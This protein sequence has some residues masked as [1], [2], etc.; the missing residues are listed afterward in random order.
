MCDRGFFSNASSTTDGMATGERRCQ[1]CSG[2]HVTP[3]SNSTSCDVTCEDGTEAGTGGIDCIVSKVCPKGMYG[4]RTGSSA[5]GNYSGCTACPAGTFLSVPGARSKDDC[6]PCSP[7]QYSSTSGAKIS[8]QCVDCERGKF[9]DKRGANTSSA[10]ISCRELGASYQDELGQASCKPDLCE[11]GKYAKPTTN[12]AVLTDPRIRTPC[13]DC[14]K[15]R[16]SLVRGLTGES[17]CTP[18]SAGFYATE[19]GATSVNSCQSCSIGRFGNASGASEASKCY[20]CKLGIEY[21]DQPGQAACK[22]AACP[23]GQYGSATSA[24]IKPP[25]SKCPK[26]RYSVAAGLVSEDECGPCPLGTYGVVEGAVSR[27]KGCRDCSANNTYGIREGQASRDT[28]CDDCQIGTYQDEAGKASCKPTS[29]P[30]GKAGIKPPN[31]TDCSTGRYSQAMGLTQCRDCPAGYVTREQGMA[32]CT[33]C[34]SYQTT[35][36]EG[37]SDCMCE[38]Q[39]YRVNF[40]CSPCPEAI[41][42][43]RIGSGLQ[44]ITLKRGMWRAG[45]DDNTFVKC[46]VNKTCIGG[47]DTAK[48]CLEGHHGP[49]CAICDKSYSR[50]TNSVPCSKCPENMTPSVFAALGAGIGMVAFLAICLFFNRRTPNGVLRPLINAAQ[51]M[52]VVFMFPVDWPDSIKGLKKA[53][54]GINLDFVEIASPACLGMP[55]SYY[56]RLASMIVVTGLVIG[57]PWLASRLRYWH[58]AAKWRSTVQGHLRDTFLL[59]VLLHPTLSGQAFA[60]FRCRTV[61]YVDQSAAAGSAYESKQYLMADYSLECYDSA[62][63]GIAALVLVVILGFSLG[64]PILFAR[65]LWVRRAELQ[66]PETK[67]LLG[68]LYMSYK[69]DLYWFESV[70]M[71]FKLALWATLVFFEHG[72]QFQLA[73][74]A[75]ICFVQLGVHARYEPYET[76]FKNLMQY[77]SYTLVAFTAF[78]GLL[79]NFIT[80]SAKLAL[81]TLQQDEYKRLRAQESTFKTGAAVFIWLG[82]SAIIVQM[83]FYAVKFCRKHGAKVRRFGSHVQSAIARLA[84]RMSSRAS[85]QEESGDAIELSMD[86]PTTT[87]AGRQGSTEAATPV[88]Q[89]DAPVRKWHP[90]PVM[91]DPIAK[92]QL[93]KNTI[94]TK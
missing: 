1:V 17:Q 56:G 76:G 39:F 43:D 54:S 3:I 45:P 27:H 22:S 52:V 38:P 12:G 5:A 40:T 55:V 14:P 83:I 34:P 57:T 2:S 11:A 71:T 89:E 25:C 53:L 87:I 65:I 70:T 29:C 41:E 92:G 18:C 6:F 88:S 28:G 50:W 74:S 72:S 7:G 67:K 66:N 84:P 32:D 46:P 81:A 21:T 82:T 42:C 13:L 94:N 37:A 68:V 30:A 85:P 90:N 36:L 78:A 79:L 9:N 8:D 19:S 23:P 73:M 63:N 20:P 44:N 60:F 91:S 58:N 31:C 69:P 48:L 80:V 62:W 93:S 77:V 16:F 64:M 75:A 10:C 4:F 26:G 59:V 49:L 61:N 15:G 86:V 51:N 35:A 24:S 33:R 47:N